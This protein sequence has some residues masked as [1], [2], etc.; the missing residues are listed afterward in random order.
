MFY[1]IGINGLVNGLGQQGCK[2]FLASETVQFVHVSDQS[3]SP[4]MGANA[5]NKI[6]AEM[7]PANSYDKCEPK[8]TEAFEMLA[9]KCATLFGD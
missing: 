5:D 4:T 6:G 9:Y 8:R 3:H 1:W 2:G 7:L